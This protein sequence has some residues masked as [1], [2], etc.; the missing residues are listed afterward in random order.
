MLD[1]PIP[2]QYIIVRDDK[3]KF[4][5]YSNGSWTNSCL[6]DSVV[7]Y[8][9]LDEAISE[10]YRIKTEQTWDQTGLKIMKMTT[11]L[12]DVVITIGED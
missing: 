2:Q 1:K 8:F 6:C 7:R 9:S 5:Y 10:L 3:E 12:S 4:N 11:L